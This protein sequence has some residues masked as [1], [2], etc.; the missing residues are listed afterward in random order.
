MSTQEQK[1]HLG[2]T[3]H[4]D[5]PKKEVHESDQTR[6]WVFSTSAHDINDRSFSPTTYLGCFEET[7]IGN[8]V[9]HLAFSHRVPLKSVQTFHHSP[10]LLYCVIEHMH[11]SITRTD[12]NRLVPNTQLIA[13]DQLRVDYGMTTTEDDS[14]EEPKTDRELRVLIRFPV[15]IQDGYDMYKITDMKWIDFLNS[16]RYEC[17]NEDDDIVYEDS[18]THELWVCFDPEHLLDGDFLHKTTKVYPINI[19]VQ[20]VSE[21]G[22]KTLLW[23]VQFKATDKLS[24]VLCLFQEQLGTTYSEMCECMVCDEEDDEYAHY[25][26]KHE[27]IKYDVLVRRVESKEVSAQA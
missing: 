21:T 8:V 18:E 9:T 6:V 26:V 12:S 27:S 16:T 11:Y 2:L 19:R 13:E 22:E 14:Q 23:H 10:E 7:C 20:K 15:N 4:F 5:E 17:L 1:C 24:A 3:P 25:S